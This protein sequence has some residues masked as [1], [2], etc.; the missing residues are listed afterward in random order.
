MYILKF[1]E[2]ERG[3]REYQKI[4]NAQNKLS[5]LFSKAVDFLKG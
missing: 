1:F 3:F 2:V 4:A 5:E